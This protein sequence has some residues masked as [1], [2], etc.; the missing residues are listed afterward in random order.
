MAGFNIGAKIAEAQANATYEK[1][2]VY[3]IKLDAQ[4]A[5]VHY[6][7]LQYFPE[8]LTDSK[9]VDWQSKPIPGGSLPLYQWT[10]SGERTISFTAQ[11]SSDLDLFNYKG[12]VGDYLNRLQA[13]GQT[14]YNVDIRSAV[15]WLRSNML[16]KYADTGGIAKTT[17]PNKLMLY[18][19]YSGIGVAGGYTSYTGV[20]RDTVVC[21]Q[22]SCEV[23]WEKFF[24]SGY[25]RM[26][27]VSLSFAQVPQYKG[28]VNFP[29][30]TDDMV[31]AYYD[32]KFNG[33]GE[34][35]DYRTNF[36]GYRVKLKAKSDFSSAPTDLKLA[37][38]GR[39]LFTLPPPTPTP[40]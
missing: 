8:S 5:P 17:P 31:K 14:K 6:A 7:A 19:P 2:A 25:P 23:T 33:K 28:I 35:K 30:A 16:P 11:F 4:D 27:S 26:A 15:A 12:P 38:N 40:P 39:D 22:T 21:V 24:P 13:A 36:L 3:L 29:A 34:A 10:G 32:D 1:S 9:A 18:I 20:S 37:A